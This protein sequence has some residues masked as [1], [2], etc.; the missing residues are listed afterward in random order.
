[1]VDHAELDGLGGHAENDGG[2]FVLGQHH[3]AGGL[4]GFGAD[5]A[6]VAHA[7]EDHADAHGTGEGRDGFHCDVDVG[8]IA[9]DAPGG[10]VEL[11]AAGEHNAKVL[12][13]GANVKGAGLHGFVDFRFFHANAGEFGELRPEFTSIR[14]KEAEV[15][16]SV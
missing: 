10:G 5:R 4:D 12:R 11:D 16:E 3:A 6:V 2:G 15:N 8:Q 13:T 7:G 1:M 14:V 9:V